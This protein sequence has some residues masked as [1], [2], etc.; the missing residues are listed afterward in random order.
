VAFVERR[1]RDRWRARYRGP[2]GRERSKTFRR[3]VDADRFLATTEADKARG[4]WIDP[5]LGRLSFTDWTERYLQTV[6][7]LKPKT[8]AGYESLLRTHITPTF[9]RVSLNRVDGVAVRQWVASLIARELAPLASD[10]R[11]SSFRR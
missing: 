2:D 4:S 7:H 9:G 6:V 5:A 8:R 1:A 3:K 10:R 11:T